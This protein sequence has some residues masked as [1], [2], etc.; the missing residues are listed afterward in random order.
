MNARSLMPMSRL[1]LVMI[2]PA[3]HSIFRL[4]L[5]RNPF[6]FFFAC[7]EWNLKIPIKTSEE[8]I[9]ETCSNFS[10]NNKGSAT[11]QQHNPRQT[12]LFSSSRSSN[13]KYSSISN[14]EIIHIESY[15]FRVILNEIYWSNNLR[16]CFK[17]CTYHFICKYNQQTKVNTPKQLNKTLN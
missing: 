3:R 4:Q 5:A 10:I 17:I 6:K 2:S 1:F 13:T 11:T 14:C 12:Q 7:Y 15:H 9:W 16:K 8:E